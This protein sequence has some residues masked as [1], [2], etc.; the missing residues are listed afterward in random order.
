MQTI[1]IFLTLAAA[2]ALTIPSM[3]AHSPSGT[4]VPVTVD[5]FTRAETDMYFRV[6]VQRSGVGTFYHHRAPPPIDLDSVRPNRDP[7][8]SE[9]V[10]DL[11]AGSVTIT[12]PDAGRRFMSMIV[13]DE[14]HYVPEVVYGAG[15]YTFTKEQIGT[16]Y[17]FTGGRTLVD[18]ANPQDVKQV[19]ALQEAIMVRQAPP[20]RFEVPHWEQVSHQKVRDALKALGET[21][22]DLNRAAGRREQVDPVRHLI[23]TAMGWGL[24]PEKDAV[25]LNVTPRQN[26]G[27]GVYTLTVTDVPVDG[28]WSVSV[29]NAAGHFVKNAFEAY[30]LNN[31]TAKQEAD[32]SFTVQFGG[33]DGTVANCLPSMPGWNYMVRLYRPRAEILNGTWKFP[34]AQSTR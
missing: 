16:R 22:P 11:E 4:A 6:F 13:I 29:Y 3:H 15:A 8:Y 10:F 2:L 26:D 12:L 23:A 27:T 19:H 1:R 7:L 31:I 25:Y 5:N 30:T 21:L 14:G 28:F 9:A 34:D 24:N 20:G 18:P 17:M 33:C 32:R